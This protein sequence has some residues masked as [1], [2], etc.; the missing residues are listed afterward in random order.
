MLRNESERHNN[1]FNSIVDEA[2]HAHI[3]GILVRRWDVTNN[4]RSGNDARAQ[5]Q[6]CLSL[7]E[8]EKTMEMILQLIVFF[9]KN[10]PMTSELWNYH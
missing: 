3:R 10:K 2:S 7:G 6:G 1:V 4:E 5:V 9:K 8:E